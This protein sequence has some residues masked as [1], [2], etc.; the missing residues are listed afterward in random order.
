[1][2]KI[3]SMLFV[4]ALTLLTFASCDVPEHEHT[5]AD[6]WKSDADF[7]WHACTV[8][9][10]TAEDG[11]AAHTFEVTTDADGKPI[12]KCTVCEATN[13]DVPTAPEH[14][15]TFAETFSTSD[16]FHWYACTTEGCFETKDKTEHSFGNPEVTYEDGKITTKYVC[17]DCGFVKTEEQTVKTEVD[18]AVSWDEAFKNFELVN[19]T[20]EI[21][22]E[23]VKDP[24]KVHINN[25]VITEKDAYYHI[26]GSV[27][28]YAVTNDDGTCSTYIRYGEDD[29]PFMLLNDKSDEYLVGAQTE[30]VI[31]VSFEQNFE[32]FTYDEA[33][34]SYVTNEI[35]DAECFTSEG[36]VLAVL[37]CYDSVVKITDGK[38]SYIE[39]KYYFDEEDLDEEIFSFKYYNIGISAVEI[40]QDVIDGAIADDGRYDDD[41]DG[42]DGE[43]SEND[44]ELDGSAHPDG[45]RY[46]ELVGMAANLLDTEKDDIIP[47]PGFEG[48]FV[49]MVLAGNSVEKFVIYT[50]AIS[51]NYGTIES[52]NLIVIS[53]EGVVEKVEK[54]VWKTSDEGY[55]FVPPSSDAVDAFYEGFPGKDNGT[56]DS[57]DIVSGAT[58]TSNVVISSVKEALSIANM[59]LAGGGNTESP[60]AK[61]EAKPEEKPGADSESSKGESGENGT[62]DVTPDSGVTGGEINKGEAE[63]PNNGDESVGNDEN[64]NIDTPENGEI[65]TEKEV[66]PE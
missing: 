15:H 46:S 47:I 41:D 48:E 7:H 39:S 40:P 54:I 44:I 17:V 14:E 10:C 30:T 12:N 60:E 8:E 56:I 5:F 50:I 9:G 58:S 36:S 63:E 38:I 42:K 65:S 52:E 34:A 55:G 22:F 62:N 64:A 2:K 35:I 21:R 20:V 24:T 26:P 59:I 61:P 13:T 33:T 16:N 51:E 66:L 3:I 57:V 4:I 27:E 31:R 25:C 11:K 6:E 37:H 45:V 53:K 19:F 29:K 18:D 43:N 23:S 32:K 49:K 1:M 28:Y